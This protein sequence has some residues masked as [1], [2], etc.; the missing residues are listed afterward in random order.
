MRNQDD[1]FLV[2]EYPGNIQT[3]RLFNA[4][5]RWSNISNAEN[6]MLRI[7]TL[8]AVAMLAFV[9]G[10]RAQHSGLQSG[11]QSGLQSGV[12]SGVQSGLQSGYAHRTPRRRERDYG[13]YAYYNPCWRVTRLKNG[14]RIVWNCQPF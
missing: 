7:P 3:C 13:P 10:A 11:V 14:N 9:Q 4:V 2:L 5:A 6:F 1:H 12:Q 8:I